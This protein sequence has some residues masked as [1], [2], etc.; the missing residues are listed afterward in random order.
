M[1]RNQ[2]GVAPGLSK[3]WIPP[4][5]L[6]YWVF[7]TSDLRELEFISL[8]GARKAV[9]CLSYLFKAFGFPKHQK[10]DVCIT[11]VVPALLHAFRRSSGA[12]NEA[13]QKKIL[14]QSQKAFGI[15]VC[16]TKPTRRTL[17]PPHLS[18]LDIILKSFLFLCLIPGKLMISNDQ[19]PRA[20]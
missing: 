16:T 6:S 14:F 17:F 4:S 7:F 18:F 2:A 10:S 11:I 13:D 12:S 20:L 19:Y 15:A 9:I 3:C 8:S 5:Y 1:F